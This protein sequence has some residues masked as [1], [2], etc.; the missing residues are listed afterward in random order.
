MRGAMAAHQN[1]PIVSTL[2]ARALV[3]LGRPEDAPE[4]FERALA[5]DPNLLDVH[6]QYAHL[7]VERGDFSGALEHARAAYKP[8]SA[9]RSPY[10][11]EGR[12]VQVLQLV[13]AVTEGLTET[14]Q[15]LGQGWFDTT[16]IPV[17]YWHSGRELPP[18]D[19]VFNAIAD[20]AACAAALDVAAWALR[21]TK[22]PVLNAPHAVRESGRISNSRRLSGIDGIVAPRVCRF[23][24]AALIAG[25]VDFGGNGFTFPVL[26]RT[27]G[28]HN[29]RN[30][31]RVESLDDV[32]PAVMSL[33]GDEIL[34]LAFVDTRREG[35]F[36]KYRAMIVNG[37]IF[38][39]HLAISTHWNVHYFSAQMGDVER[40]HEKRFLEDMQGAL[41]ARATSALQQ[42]AAVLGLEYAG[43]DFGLNDRGDVVLFEAS[44]AMTL[45]VPPAGIDTEY[46]RRAAF[47]IF[48]AA[49]Q[50]VHDAVR[51]RSLLI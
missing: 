14:E 8:V 34:V 25:T 50:M 33:P 28:E 2:Y 6:L 4:H 44:A 29:G 41:G 40:E 42:I 27:P 22:A 11:G 15:F 39:A 13:S 36:W 49:R 32:V 7:L 24:R 5:L 46:R 37:E 51:P 10:T 16:T 9:W 45:F 1:N 12:T 43:I 47:R 20:P 23:S 19:V 17:Q 30:F 48:A 35:R 21:Q 3:S 31:V 38:P 26:L 18:H